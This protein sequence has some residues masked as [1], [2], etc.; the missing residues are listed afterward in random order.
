MNIEDL[1]QTLAQMA[2]EVDP[3][4][5]TNRLR[6]VEAKVTAARRRRVG[7]SAGVVAAG[8]A[9]ALLVPGLVN[10]SPDSSDPSDTTSTTPSSTGS[11]LPVVEDKGLSFYTSPAGDT[12]LGESV[13]RPGERSVSLRVPA[14]TTDLAYQSVCWQRGI[15]VRGPEMYHVTINGR[16]IADISCG[17]E[18]PPG[19]LGSDGRFGSSPK[20]NRTLW[21]GDLGVVPGE[22]VTLRVFLRPWQGAAGARPPQLGI[23]LYAETGPIV[24]IHGLWLDRQQVVG[25]HTYRLVR[26]QIT[27]VEGLSGR[28]SLDLPSAEAPLYVV[29]GVADVHGRYWTDSADS[30]SGISASTASSTSDL[31]PVGQRRSTMSI[32]LRR[33]PGALIYLLAYERID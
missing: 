6:G 23:A 33:A 28:V 29:K 24:R 25:G 17:D 11:V 18:P 20:A 2:D 10:G 7:A 9:L 16:P 8:A 31:E 21:R 4:D 22:P 19:P 32:H 27:Q 15:P 14:P 5:E 30:S 3:L 26:S 12:L 13:G 1:K